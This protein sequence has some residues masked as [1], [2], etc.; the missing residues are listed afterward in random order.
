MHLSTPL[1]G[2]FYG[3]LAG[4]SV[5]TLDIHQAPLDH[6]VTCKTVAN[7]GY[8]VT[9]EPEY[10][11]KGPGVYQIISLQAPERVAAKASG[12]TGAGVVS[13]NPAAEEFAQQWFFAD[14]GY[15]HSLIINRQT[16]GPLTSLGNGKQTEAAPGPVSTRN[17]WKI[18]AAQQGPNGSVVLRNALYNDLVLDLT[19][20]N[21]RPDTPII[22]YPLN[23][24]RGTPNQ[25]WLLKHLGWIA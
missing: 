18:E 13:S 8:E 1:L 12:A 11:Y 24:P 17:I 15:N 10:G 20:S 4:A 25:I 5:I 19:A 6:S 16:G 21:P 3:V 2:V 23:G 22:S 9:A 14:W 7:N